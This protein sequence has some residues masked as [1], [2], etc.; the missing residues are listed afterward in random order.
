[1]SIF[2]CPNCG[3]QWDSA[4]PWWVCDC[5]AWKVCPVCM[6]QGKQRGPYGVGTKCGQCPKGMMRERRF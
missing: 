5:C 6:S 1:M 4:A 3:R 2:L